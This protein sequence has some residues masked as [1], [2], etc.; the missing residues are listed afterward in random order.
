MIDAL[1]A[2]QPAGLAGREEALDLAVYAA[3]GLDVAVLVDRAGD[4][5]ALVE[6]EA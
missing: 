1:P 6:R 2:G 3:D 5:D 4:G